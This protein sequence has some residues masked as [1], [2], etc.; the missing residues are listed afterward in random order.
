MYVRPWL[1]GKGPV[2]LSVGPSKWVVSKETDVGR[3]ALISE[4]FQKKAFAETTAMVRST[5][6]RTIPDQHL[7]QKEVNAQL[8][9]TSNFIVSP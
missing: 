6:G 1:L 5:K 8:L 4:Q 9:K 7:S 3:L 2:D